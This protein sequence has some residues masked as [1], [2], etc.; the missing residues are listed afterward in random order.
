[1]LLSVQQQDPQHGYNRAHR[2]RQVLDNRLLMLEQILSDLY[3][4]DHDWSVMLLR[5]FNP[6]G[7]H[8]RGLIGED[9][10]GIP[11]NLPRTFPQSPVLPSNEA[12]SAPSL[13]QNSRL[14]YRLGGEA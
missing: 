12:P 14:Q 8:K 9:R 11:N 7:A 1:M 3:V 4:P 2:F 13:H 5:Y 6:I 10:K